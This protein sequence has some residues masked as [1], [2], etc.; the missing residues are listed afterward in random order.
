MATRRNLA[1]SLVRAALFAG[2]RGAAAAAG[3]AA[4][5]LFIWW[6]QTR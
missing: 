4:I 5:A 2:V 1:R 3:S 6:L